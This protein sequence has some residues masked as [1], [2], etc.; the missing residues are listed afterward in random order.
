M[1]FT[2]KVAKAMLAAAAFCAVTTPPAGAQTYPDRTIA[3][4]IPFAAGGSSDVIARLIGEEMGKAL[5]QRLVPENI[6]GAGGS[7]ALARV[8]RAAPDGYTIVIGNAGTNA[9]TY[10]IHKNLTFTPDDFVAVAMVAKTS[11][12]IALKKDHPAS[13]AK[14]FLAYARANPGKVNLGHAGVGSSNYLICQ[15]FIKAAKIEVT[16]VGYRGAAPALQDA[17]A[18][19]IDGVCDAATSLSS[20]ITSKAVKPI[21]VSGDTRIPNFPDIPTGQEVGLPDFQ[22]QGWNA[23]FVPKG[24][25]RPI[26]DRLNQA[27][28]AALES[29]LVKT[30]FEQLASTRPTEAERTPEFIA[31]LVPKEIEKYRKLMEGAA[32]Q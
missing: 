25:P 1:M 23:I 29:D 12:I 18:G 8:A 11:P 19:T 5:G 27:A 26:I 9:A 3:M 21:V 24:T 6:G 20:A 31:T 4:I 30:R 13:T 7:T 17:M 2:T 28:R 10:S 14:D 15:S 32:S 16:L 22:A